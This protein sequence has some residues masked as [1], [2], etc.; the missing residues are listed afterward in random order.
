M[1]PE[2]PWQRYAGPLQACRKPA[3]SNRFDSSF[4][5]HRHAAL[6]QP[7][8]SFKLQHPEIQALAADARRERTNE[9]PKIISPLSL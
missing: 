5:R 7:A 6:T 4:F 1:R 9:K 3:C 2:K 8:R